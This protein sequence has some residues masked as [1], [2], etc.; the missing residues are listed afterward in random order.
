MRSTALFPPPRRP[1]GRGTPA[2]NGFRFLLLHGRWTGCD[3]FPRAPIIPA[4]RAISI[5]GS[6]ALRV[7]VMQVY[8]VGDGD[9]RRMADFGDASTAEMG[10]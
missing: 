7:P 5:A 4:H 1:A 10:T 3:R 9:L 6:N 8:G 2:R